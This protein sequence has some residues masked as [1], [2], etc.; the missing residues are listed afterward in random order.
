MS[1]PGIN[2]WG[3]NLFW[4]RYWFTDV[5][6][7]LDNHL[8]DL[9]ET[10]I[11]SYAKYGVLFNTN[12]LTNKYWWDSMNK[13]FG[14]VYAYN[15]SK[16]FRIFEYR[17]RSTGELSVYRMRIA[18]KVQYNSKIWILRC[19]NW[20]IINYYCFMPL[21]P[22]QKLAK[23]KRKTQY[24]SAASEFKKYSPSVIFRYKILLFSVL[25]RFTAVND[26]YRF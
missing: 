1:H 25:N 2:R 3:L 11:Y 21:S 5:N 16:Y 24:I 8:D 6:M 26:Y 19:Q 17:N 12:P 9:L 18:V 22:N 23:S 13:E 20:L 7:H 15:Y 4:Y 14:N 10:F